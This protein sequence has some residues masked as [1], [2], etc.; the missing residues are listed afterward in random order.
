MIWALASALRNVLYKLKCIVF[1]LQFWKLLHFVHDFI[2]WS[3]KI[4][5]VKILNSWCLKCKKKISSQIL[6]TEMKKAFFLPAL[7]STQMLT[8]LVQAASDI[9]I[10]YY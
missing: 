2:E 5:G 9:D 4:Q 7:S 10:R 6:I 1:E 3:C 8:V